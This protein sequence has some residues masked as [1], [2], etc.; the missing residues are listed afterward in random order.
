MES[1]ARLV[2]LVPG[3]P[4]EWSAEEDGEGIV[5]ELEAPWLLE[6]ANEN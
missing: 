4:E 1:R 2:E 6:L 5:D 3:D